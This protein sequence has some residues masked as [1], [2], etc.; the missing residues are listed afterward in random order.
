[1]S[2][3]TADILGG[4]QA[5]DVATDPAQVRKWTGRKVDCFLPGDSLCTMEC[6]YHN[7]A[8]ILIKKKV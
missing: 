8:I 2:L 7:Q 6:S 1:M 3:V 5:I 4:T